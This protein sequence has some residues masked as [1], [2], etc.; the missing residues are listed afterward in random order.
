MVPVA[1]KLPR[2]WYQKKLNW[3]LGFVLFSIIVGGVTHQPRTAQQIAEDKASFHRKQMASIALST[4]RRSLRNPDTLDVQSLSS[5]ESGNIICI[6]YRAQNG[7]GGVTLA[8][9]VFTAKGGTDS[10]RAWNRNCAHK[11]LYD[12]T[13]SIPYLPT[14]SLH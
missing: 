8:Q 1:P 10:A 13:P 12:L 7:F 3:F 2:R 6:E 14:T 5:S 4:L 11:S 9:T